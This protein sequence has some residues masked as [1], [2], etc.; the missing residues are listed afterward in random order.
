MR[1]VAISIRY[2]NDIFTRQCH[3]SCMLSH[4]PFLRCTHLKLYELVGS[5]T[6]S[7]RGRYEEW[8]P[9]VTISWILR[10]F[11]CLCREHRAGSRMPTPYGSSEDRLPK[12]DRTHAGHAGHAD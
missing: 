3:S 7:P 12:S 10:R 9:A 5:S 1:I 8:L 11:P 2:P 4:P 6:V